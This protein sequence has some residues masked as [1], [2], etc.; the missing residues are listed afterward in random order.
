MN[1]TLRWGRVSRV[2]TYGTPVKTATGKG[3]RLLGNLGF[4]AKMQERVFPIGTIWL[5][6]EKR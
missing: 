4:C 5:S 1:M 6:S 2:R 3:T